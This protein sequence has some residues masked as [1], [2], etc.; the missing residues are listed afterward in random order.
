MTYYRLPLNSRKNSRLPKRDISTA[1]IIVPAGHYSICPHCKK[2]THV[3]NI[4]GEESICFECDKSF[5][6]T[7]LYKT[8]GFAIF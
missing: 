1:R 5:I 2:E 7:K 6:I 8:E 4:I 3:V